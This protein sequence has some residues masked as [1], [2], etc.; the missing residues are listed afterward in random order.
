MLFTGETAVVDGRFQAPAEATMPLL[1]GT[2]AMR[3]FAGADT[4]AATSAVVGDAASV[5][6]GVTVVAGG[7]K[8]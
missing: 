6:I 4:S 7:G 2:D 5:V 3:D 1:G 8:G